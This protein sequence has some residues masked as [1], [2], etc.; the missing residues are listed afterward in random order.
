[1]EVLALEEKEIHSHIKEN[2]DQFG[3]LNIAD[4]VLNTIAT[5]AASEIKGVTTLSSGIAGGIAEMF[6]GKKSIGKG[7]KV[8]SKEGEMKIDISLVVDYGVRIP[9][10]AWEVQDNVKKSIEAMTG[11]QVAQINIHV[12]GINFGSEDTEQEDNKALED[13]KSNK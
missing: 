8:D 11:L 7:V 10:V 3:N 4:D 1:M 13:L 6:G 5:I 9:D 12:Q 2:E